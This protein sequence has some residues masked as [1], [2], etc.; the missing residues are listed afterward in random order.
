M[1]A[2][3]LVLA[4]GIILEGGFGQTSEGFTVVLKRGVAASFCF[5]LLSSNPYCI[6][7]SVRYLF[8]LCLPFL[9]FLSMPS[10]AQNQSFDACARSV[11]H[12]GFASWLRI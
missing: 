10:Q 11:G 2:F 3:C 9:L 12:K 5:A 8:A 4:P 7:S 6:C 1:V